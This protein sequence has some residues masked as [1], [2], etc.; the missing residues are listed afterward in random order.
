MSTDGSD[1]EY[2]SPRATL[3]FPIPSLPYGPH[4]S[5]QTGLKHR[6]NGIVLGGAW[7]ESLIYTAERLLLSL[8]GRLPA[9][10]HAGH[11]GHGVAVYR[12]GVPRVDTD[13]SIVARLAVPP[14]ME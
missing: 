2:P 4:R 10:Q 6:S 9:P 13:T 12:E 14:P 11:P 1:E 7:M 8:M 5:Y 3:S